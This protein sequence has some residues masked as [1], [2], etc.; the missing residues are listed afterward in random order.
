MLFSQEFFSQE[1]ALNHVVDWFNALP[2]ASRIIGPN[3]MFLV[4]VKV[5]TTNS[6]EPEFTVYT[7][8]DPTADD[9]SRMY[10]GECVFMWVGVREV[11]ATASVSS[12]Y[13]LSKHISQTMNVFGVVG[14]LLIAPPAP[15]PEAVL[16]R[17]GYN[18]VGD[19]S[20]TVGLTGAGQ[21][22][23]QGDLHD[24]GGWT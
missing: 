14:T 18:T 9:S 4:R 20:V 1:A 19:M 15:G 5:V 8:T 10:L 13:L 12:F 21:P 23:I 22:V 6:G 17:M 16:F 24:E 3:E 2:D 11:V 7:T